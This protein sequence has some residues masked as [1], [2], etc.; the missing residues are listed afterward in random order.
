MYLF[1]EGV[2]KALGEDGEILSFYFNIV[3]LKRVTVVGIIFPCTPQEK[4]FPTDPADLWQTD[5]ASHLF[6]LTGIK[7]SP[8][9]RTW[10]LLIGR[11]ATTEQGE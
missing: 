11:A 7:L 8:L 6:S 1:N 3:H 2:S 4:H 9:S 10:S 5:E